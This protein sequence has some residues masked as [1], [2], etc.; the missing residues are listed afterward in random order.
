[1]TV[2][3]RDSIT[4]GIKCH[5]QGSEKKKSRFEQYLMSKTCCCKTDHNIV[6][7]FLFS[8]IVFMQ[9]SAVDGIHA[10]D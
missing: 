4:S 5:L 9:F 10:A 8:K 1:M 3:F 2:R 6:S 7:S